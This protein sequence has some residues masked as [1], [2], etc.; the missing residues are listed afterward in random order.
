LAEIT[1]IEIDGRPF[2]LR[3]VG[4]EVWDQR[5]VMAAAIAESLG[6]SHEW[7]EGFF[8]GNL[9]LSMELFTTIAGISGFD[10]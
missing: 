9:E 7:G 3:P 10:D 6:K 5:N 1:E 8:F 2:T 4:P